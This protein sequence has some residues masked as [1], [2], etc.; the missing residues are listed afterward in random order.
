MKNVRQSLW[1]VTLWATLALGG[2]YLLSKDE[3]WTTD[4]ISQARNIS[5]P[6][7]L[8]VNASSA[9]VA[10]I[11]NPPQEL[12]Q[13]AKDETLQYIADH[14]KVREQV[15]SMYWFL[16]HMR[17]DSGYN[18]LQI[19]QFVTNIE[20]INK[21]LSDN[22]DVESTLMNVEW[23]KN[24][25]NGILVP[26]KENDII[27]RIQLHKLNEAKMRWFPESTRKNIIQS[28]WY[29]NMDPVTAMTVIS[30][31]D[32]TVSM[33]WSNSHFSKILARY[34]ITYETL[35]K[36]DLSNIDTWMWKVVNLLLNIEGLKSNLS[37]EL[38][39][40]HWGTLDQYH[41]G[42]ADPENVYRIL[43]ASYSAEDEN[44]D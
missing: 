44:S 9:Q 21:Y 17:W 3:H 4:G 41:Q 23:W 31:F 38:L 28:T 40:V 32:S 8:I 16:A 22:P 25:K 27:N 35:W 33:M 26:S 42:S 6:T 12:E 36:E 19:Q 30:S 10:N 14:P 34:N 24:Y 29:Q 13:K 37:P 20:S 15:Y 11:I 39:M 7:N 18:W 2:T 5:T 43:S 1:L